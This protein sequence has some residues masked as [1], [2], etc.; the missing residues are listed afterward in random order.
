MRDEAD[1]KT[2][3]PFFDTHS[4][5]VR[6]RLWPIGEIVPQ[7]RHPSDLWNTLAR[8]SAHPFRVLAVSSCTGSHEYTDDDRTHSEAMIGLPAGCPKTLKPIEKARPSKPCSHR[9]GSDCVKRAIW[10]RP[11]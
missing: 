4:A 2:G 7:E 1:G 3:P 6:A 8:T 5:N 9:I 10:T 11:G